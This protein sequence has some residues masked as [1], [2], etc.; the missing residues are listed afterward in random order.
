MEP[1]TFPELSVICFIPYITIAVQEVDVFFDVP[2]HV[3]PSFF[4]Y[5]AI[6]VPV[7]WHR[8]THSGKDA[9]ECDWFSHFTTFLSQGWKLVEI[10]F[11]SS[12]RHRGENVVLYNAPPYHFCSTSAMN[13]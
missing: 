3:M 5:Q 9:L 1:P 2:R 12:V 13:Q 6:S 10:L 8:E 11:D 4:I 7:L